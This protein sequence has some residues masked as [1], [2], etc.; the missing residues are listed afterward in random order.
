VVLGTA[1]LD[2][3]EFARQ[4]AR[5]HPQR[6]AI[7]LDYRRR[8]D[9]TLETAA[10]G[11]IESSGRTVASV[12]EALGDVPLGAAVVTAIERDGTLAGPDLDG[13]AHVLDATTVPVVASGGV[14]ALAD[15]E[16]LVALRGPRSGRAL[17][18]AIAGKAL[19]DGRIDAREALAVCATSA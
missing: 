15:L 3:P 16:A 7:G 1:A 4:A 2:D 6:V 5:R 17:I 19:A 18:G 14:G 11:W 10:R 8:A 9:G 12:L 13:L